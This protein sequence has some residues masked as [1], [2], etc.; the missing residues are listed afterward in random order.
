MVTTLFIDFSQAQ[1]QLTPKSVMESCRNANSS[2]LVWLFLLPAR[3]KKLQPKMKELA[4]SQYF[5]HYNHIGSICRHGNQRSDLILPKTLCSQF[6]T[7]MML[8]MK[9]DYDWPAGLRDIHVRKCGRTH[10]LTDTSLS[11]IL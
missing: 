9:F 5:P 7:P 4:W 10:G 6:P 11:P 3:M 1:G 8:Q 2:K